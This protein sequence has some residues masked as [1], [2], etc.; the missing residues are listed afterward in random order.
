MI[1]HMLQFDDQAEDAANVYTSIFEDSKIVN[2]S[3][4]SDGKAFTVNFELIG[5]RYIG[6]NGGPGEPQ[7]VVAG[8]RIDLVSLGR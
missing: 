3:R 5:E 4:N 8:S 1:C 2:V 6:L 7:V